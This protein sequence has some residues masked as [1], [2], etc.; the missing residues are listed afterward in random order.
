MS[1]LPLLMVDGVTEAGTSFRASGRGEDVFGTS[2][3]APE[4]ASLRL[5]VETSGP[6]L[7]PTV[8]E[9]VLLDRVPEGLRVPG[10]STRRSWS[11]SPRMTRGPSSWASSTT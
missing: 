9:R 4:L 3:G 10:A 1:G 2:T 11:R 7:Q 6:G 5:E 8:A